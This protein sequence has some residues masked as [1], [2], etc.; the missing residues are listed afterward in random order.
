MT[1][2]A[3]PPPVFP[4]PASPV[5]A[6]GAGRVSLSEL[7][8]AL[9]RSLDMTEGQPPGHTLR[10]CYI[11]MRLAERVGLGEAERK[12]LY[13]ALLLKDA[14]C[15]SNAARVAALFG[16]DDHGVKFRRMVSQSNIMV[17]H[18]GSRGIRKSSSAPLCEYR[19]FQFRC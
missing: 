8:S 14:G 5:T 2:T 11:G 4:S 10:T 12:A 9:S 16:S 6:G 19:L 7:L 3:P 13:Y 17:S 1:I 18:G 15:S